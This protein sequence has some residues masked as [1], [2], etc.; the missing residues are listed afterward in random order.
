M[1]PSF[2]TL[3]EWVPVKS[4]KMDVCA[5]LCV[6]YLTHDKVD[7]VSFADGQ[8]VMPDI[9]VTPEQPL[10]K[11][12]RIIIFQEFSSMAQLLQNVRISKSSFISFIHV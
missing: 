6:H 5:K 10:Q 1:W 9:I 3:E 7:D 4:T 8:P 12:R 2:K 11:T